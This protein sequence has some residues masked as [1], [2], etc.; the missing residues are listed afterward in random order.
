MDKFLSPSAR[1]MFFGDRRC[2]AQSK[3]T[4]DRCQRSAAI[5][6]FVCDKHGAKTPEAIRVGKER[7]LMLLEPALGALYRALQTAPPCP[8]CGRSDSDRDPTTVRAA[9]L[10]LDRCGFG[11]TANMN[12][13]VTEEP[14][15]R[16]ERVIVDPVNDTPAIDG[17]CIDVDSSGE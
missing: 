7:L 5:G 17:I 13:L 8:A 11:P 4:G 1:P 14:I 3:G 9:Q 15:E 2:T 12:V 10:V 6:Q 16:I